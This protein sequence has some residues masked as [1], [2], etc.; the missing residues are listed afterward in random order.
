[1]S[2]RQRIVQILCC[3]SQAALTIRVKACQQLY[4]TVEFDDGIRSLTQIALG[5]TTSREG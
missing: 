3:F 2:I 5:C 4:E 1:M